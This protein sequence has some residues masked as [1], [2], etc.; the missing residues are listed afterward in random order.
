MADSTWPKP[1]LSQISFAQDQAVLEA[2][3]GGLAGRLSA[4]VSTLRDRLIGVIAHIEA[5]IDFP[6]MT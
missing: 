6:R 1:K 5:E 4:E 2:G 3:S